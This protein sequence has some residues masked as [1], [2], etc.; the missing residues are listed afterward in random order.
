[1]A[2]VQRIIVGGTSRALRGIVRVTVKH[3]GVVVFE[4]PAFESTEIVNCTTCC[5]P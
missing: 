4:W 3:Y 1:M 5:I 2:F